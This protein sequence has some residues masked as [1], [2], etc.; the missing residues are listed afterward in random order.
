LVEFDVQTVGQE[1]DVESLDLYSNLVITAPFPF[2]PVHVRVFALDAETP[3]KLV[4]AIGRPAGLTAT[5][6]A[7]AGDVPTAFLAVSWKV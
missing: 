4:G 7:D 5:D 6:F 2:A 3:T 1:F